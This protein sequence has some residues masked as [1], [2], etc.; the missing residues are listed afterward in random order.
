MHQ[1][2]S[3]R[4]DEE[5]YRHPDSVTEPKEIGTIERQSQGSRHTGAQTKIRQVP[6]H[7]RNTRR[8]KISRF[9]HQ[10]SEP[11]EFDF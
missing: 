8:F 9:R 2:C 7:P 5:V 11:R 10:L 6:E 4:P 1:E 3:K